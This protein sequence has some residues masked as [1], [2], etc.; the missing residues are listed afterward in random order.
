MLPKVSPPRPW[1][2]D[3]LLDIGRREGGKANYLKAIPILMLEFWITG[4]RIIDQ[5]NYL[6]VKWAKNRIESSG[7]R[8]PFPP[9]GTSN[10]IGALS[11]IQKSR[12][13][14][15]PLL[16]Y[17]KPGIAWINLPNYESLLEEYRQKY[18]NLYP[19]DY[20]K[21][22]PNP[23][24]VPEW[25]I[26]EKTTPSEIKSHGDIIET[27]DNQKNNNDVLSSDSYSQGQPEKLTI[28]K[29][30]ENYEKEWQTRLE[31]AEKRANNAEQEI[32]QLKEELER[33][34][35]E[36][37]DITEKINQSIPDQTK[38]S[39]PRIPEE[40]RVNVWRRDG[41][42]CARCGSRENLEFDHIVPISKG[43]SNTTRNI[44]L[45]CEKCNRSKGNR[46]I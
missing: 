7:I 20:K 5:A 21:L 26:S 36:I 39:R 9:K 23:N 35:A 43:G 16:Q 31:R 11:T 12:N 18:I 1:E 42:E 30:L 29:V 24:N 40:I 34:K 10:I 33:Y 38:Y 46:M 19:E 6:R 22:F 27:D 44:E 13:L 3:D 14:N 4:E 45:L 17:L 2:I 15:P 32:I 28:I 25:L 41:G 8:E 37:N